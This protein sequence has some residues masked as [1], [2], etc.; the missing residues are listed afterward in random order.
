[1][2]YTHKTLAAGRWHSLTMNEQMGN[3]GSEISR[4]MKWKN[5]NT[6]LYEKAIFRALELVDITLNDAR[7]KNRLKEIARLREVVC[8]AF[9]EG[10]EYGTTLESL[11]KYLNPFAMAARRMVNS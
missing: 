5:R 4:A 1:M 7:W 2:D 8:D 6:D 11:E 10:V 9:M 3:I